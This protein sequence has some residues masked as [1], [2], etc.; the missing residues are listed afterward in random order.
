MKI[1]PQNEFKNRYILPKA[2][3]VALPTAI[4]DILMQLRSQPKPSI[5]ETTDIAPDIAP[6]ERKEPAIEYE[7]INHIKRIEIKELWDKFDIDWPVDKSVSILVGI[8]GSG[9]STI[10]ELT[11]SALAD[12]YEN[13]EK[14]KYPPQEFTIIFNNDEKLSYQRTES[15]ITCIAKPRSNLLPYLI[16]TFSAPPELDEREKAETKTTAAQIERQL[17]SRLWE[18]IDRFIDELNNLEPLQINPKPHLDDFLHLINEEVFIRN[19]KKLEFVGDVKFTQEWLNKVLEG[20]EVLD[21]LREQ[22]KAM[23]SD[24]I[25][26]LNR[27]FPDLLES[28]VGKY[29][30]LRFR[31]QILQYVEDVE[32][33]PRSQAIFRL[34]DGRILMPDQLSSGEKQILIILFTALILKFRMLANPDLRHVLII[35]EPENS[36]HL[37]WQKSLI[38]YIRRLNDN[39]QII[40]ATHAPAI[41]KK[42]YME[43]TVEMNQ[44]KSAGRS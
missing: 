39:V 44:I 36:L 43:N 7:K 13:P 23:I 21:D 4:E 28:K 29:F 8:N 33:S 6:Q 42:G 5:K 41:I 9:K 31:S 30:A 14:V 34:N 18:R 35:D 11:N 20:N 27:E 3:R 38:S 32:D 25:Y 15:G 16:S 26:R 12:E 37:K 1:E 2:S 24:N 22:L 17:T 40:I 10:L 19:Q